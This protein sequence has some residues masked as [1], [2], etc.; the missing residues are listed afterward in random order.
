M[1]RSVAL[2]VL[3]V[4]LLLHGLV[5]LGVAWYGYSTTQEV[6]DQVGGE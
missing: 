1:G 2:S 5:G 3:G 4:V 6:L